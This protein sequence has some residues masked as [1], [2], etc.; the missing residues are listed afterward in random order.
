GVAAAL[1]RHARRRRRRP[2]ARDAVLRR[3]RAT[4]AR[5]DRRLLPPQRPGGGRGREC[6][7][8]A[9][10]GLPGL[11]HHGRDLRARDRR[12]DRVRAV[13]ALPPGEGEHRAARAAGEPRGS[14]QPR[15][16]G[17][18]G[19][20]GR[21][22][23]HPLRVPAAAAALHGH[24]RRVLLPAGPQPARGRLCR[25]AHLLVGDHRAVH[26][27]R[28]DLGGGPPQALAPPLARH[29]AAGGRRDRG[30][31][32]AVRLSLPH[33]PHGA[34]ACSPAGRDPRPERGRLRSR[35]VRGRG[36]GEHADPRGAGA[37]VGAQPSR[38]RGARAGHR[39]APAVGPARGGRLMEAVVSIGIGVL[40]GSGIWLVLRPRTFQVITGL[41]LMSYAVNLFIFLM[42]RLWIDRAP[43]VG[44]GAV[45]PALHADPLPQ[46]LVL[47]AIVIGFATTALYLV[48]MI[49]ARGLTDTDHVDGE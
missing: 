34:P 23:L 35:R 49:G 26:A 30:R 31:G 27:G 42:G 29:R 8:R 24:G 4:A 3:A 5:A 44:A 45:D 14:G 18:A 47:T 12:P 48:V 41:L 9:A 16:A 43:I 20:A 15:D 19:G 21:L 37:P 38:P 11:R 40:F 36:G 33:Q 10:R 28:H 25:R 22:P 46:A 39:G 7:E 6:R 13:A 2:G 1:A 17:R 32:L